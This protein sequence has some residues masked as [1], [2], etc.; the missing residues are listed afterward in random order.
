MLLYRA[1]T[2]LAVA[3]VAHHVAKGTSGI[4]VCTIAGWLES[5]GRTASSYSDE[6]MDM[7]TAYFASK[8]APDAVS[9]ADDAVRSKLH[10]SL[11]VLFCGSAQ[12]LWACALLSETMLKPSLVI[13]WLHVYYSY[14]CTGHHS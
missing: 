14:L 8:V 12:I 7:F 3:A 2:V 9:A 13:W 10:L 1:A 5:G 6:L 11:M 4:H